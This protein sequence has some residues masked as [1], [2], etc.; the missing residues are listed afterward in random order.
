MNVKITVI[1]PVFNASKYIED[2]FNSLLSQTFKDF[3]VIFINDR[4]TDNSL[5]LIEDLS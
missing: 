5:E 4:S 3:E 1:I 2:T